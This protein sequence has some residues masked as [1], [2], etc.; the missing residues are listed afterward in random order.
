MKKI[1]ILTAMAEEAQYI[2]D[3]FGLQATKKL[4]NISFFENEEIVLVLT[5][6]GKI[7]ASIGTTLL[8]TNYELSR[9]VNI[10]IAG[11]LLG[12]E[13]NIGEVFLVNK[14][15]QHDMYLPFDG[16][17]LDYAKGQITLPSTLQR[18][19]KAENWVFTD[20]SCLTGDQFIDDAE[21]VQQLRAKTQAHVVEME[22]F[23][24]ASVAR[25]FGL[26][27]K[28]VIIKAIS[29]GADADARA[30]HAG[31]LDLAMRK[32][33]EVLKMLLKS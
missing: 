3:L 22:A 4:Q 5:G 6:I 33:I 21:K 14:V 15:A 32:S 7:Q 10:G 23:A 9:L 29:D 24:V 26:L 1:W 30:A 31:N 20:A 2:I 28:L 8:C 12:Q 19:E 17:H 27:E 18:A 11:S 16:E 25:E 13:A